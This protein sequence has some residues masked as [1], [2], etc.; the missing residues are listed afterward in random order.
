MKSRLS[1]K[2]YTQNNLTHF[3]SSRILKSLSSGLLQKLIF[4]RQQG[5]RIAENECKTTPN[6]AQP[7]GFNKTVLAFA[8]LL[9]GGV[10]S[11]LFLIFE[12]ILR[13]IN[14]R[15]TLN[16]AFHIFNNPMRRR[17]RNERSLRRK[18]LQKFAW[19]LE[20]YT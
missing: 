11:L 6:V 12:R 20:V 18:E 4:E 14:D 15:V 3:I 16:K 13:F 9:F 8:V 5:R 10:A 17:T 19:D 2:R 1:L 7:L